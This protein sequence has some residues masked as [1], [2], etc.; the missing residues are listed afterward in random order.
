MFF[1]Y[2]VS[3]SE[4]ETLV[5]LASKHN[6]AIIPYGGNLIIFSIFNNNTHIFNNNIPILRPF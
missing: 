3:Q 2:K 5:N 6:V 1:S 4:V